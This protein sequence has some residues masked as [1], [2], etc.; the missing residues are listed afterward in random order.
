MIR[1]FS[2]SNTHNSGTYEW[3]LSLCVWIMTSFNDVR[4]DISSDKSTNPVPLLA[5]L[6]QS[7]G[8]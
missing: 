8:K 4:E 7:L 6:L 5:I 3:V 1:L 2:R